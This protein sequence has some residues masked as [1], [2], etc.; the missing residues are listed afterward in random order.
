M[1][2]DLILA[3]QVN[4]KSEN[5]RYSYKILKDSS[6]FYLFIYIFFWD[7]EVTHASNGFHSTRVHAKICCIC[8]MGLDPR[9]PLILYLAWKSA[10]VTFIA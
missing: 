3:R 2:G 9:F 6:R 1:M 7:W 5:N 10:L 8:W 4:G